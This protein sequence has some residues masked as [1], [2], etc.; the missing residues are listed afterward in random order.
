MLPM[1]VCRFE[2]LFGWESYSSAYAKI[3]LT[4]ARREKIIQPLFNKNIYIYQLATVETANIQPNFSL[5]NQI[6]VR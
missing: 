2:S 4:T 6:W 1:I 5:F 3:T